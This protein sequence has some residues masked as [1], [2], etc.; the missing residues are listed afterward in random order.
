MSIVIFTPTFNRGHLLKRVYSSLLRQSFREFYWLIIDDGSADNTKHV[1]NELIEEGKLKIDYHY[2]ENGGK[3]TAIQK[4]C[5]IAYADYIII[6]DSDDEL[7]DNAVEVFVN[8]WNEIRSQSKESEYSEIRAGTQLKDGTPVGKWSFPSEI[9]FIDAT[10]HEMVLKFRNDNEMI[11]CARLSEL[12]KVTEISKDTLLTKDFRYLSEFVFWARYGRSKI[13]FLNKN[14]RIYYVDSNNSIMR[15]TDSLVG[16]NDDLVSYK[17]FCEENFR[18]FLWR[19]KYFFNLIL[20][21]QIC[22]FILSLPITSIFPKKSTTFYRLT[23]ILLIV[24][25]FLLYIYM[26]YG[27][28]QFWR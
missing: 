10:W 20:K 6:L 13:R 15:N 23:F 9:Q 24:P 21:Y 26:K 28:K 3:Y 12:K 11:S 8:A 4:A 1:V 19:P 17:I 22:S 5:Q 25:S 18:Y 27:K 2:K 16:F 14:L 7:E